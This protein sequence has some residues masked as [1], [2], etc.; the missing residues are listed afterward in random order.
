MS[1]RKK[2][3]SNKLEKNFY[4]EKNFKLLEDV[5]LEMID[6]KSFTENYKELIF[7]SME[8]VYKENSPPITLERNDRKKWMDSLN[9]NVLSTIATHVKNNKNKTPQPPQPS[10]SSQPPKP[11]Q[12]SQQFQQLEHLQQLQLK[13]HPQQSQQQSLQQSQLQQKSNPPQHFT[14]ISE[15]NLGHPLFGNQNS[16]NSNNINQFST[17]PQLND[18]NERHTRELFQPLTTPSLH[19]IQHI[20]NLPPPQNTKDYKGHENSNNTNSMFEQS[21][22]ERLNENKQDKKTFDFRLPQNTQ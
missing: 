15:T 11:S 14:S 5:L 18:K 3:N 9:K 1:V 19:P 21:E 6:V 20:D 7:N 12:P 22:N 8:K 17:F 13:L 10:Q 4:S 2:I 16:T